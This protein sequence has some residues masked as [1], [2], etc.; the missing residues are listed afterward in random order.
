MPGLMRPLEAT[1]LSDGSLRYLCLLA[2]LID[3]GHIQR[4]IGEWKAEGLDPKT[5]RNLWGTVSLIW[6]AALA[7]KFVD[8]LLPRPKLPAR[9]KKK[10]KFFTLD[11]VG[12]IIANTTCEQ[13]LFYWLAAETGL[14]AGE[15]A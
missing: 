3:A 14:R 2:A 15:L 12:C 4:L 9:I 13:K 5:I 1:E 8:S 10:A 11:N 7:Q 6:Q